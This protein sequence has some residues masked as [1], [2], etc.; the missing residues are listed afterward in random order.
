[1][2][3][4]VGDE[5]GQGELRRVRQTEQAPAGEVQPQDAPQMTGGVLAHREIGAIDRSLGV[6]GPGIGYVIHV[7]SVQRI[8]YSRLPP[9][10][11]AVR[12]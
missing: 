5:L 4:D 11:N 12:R 6:T 1:M 3:H 10:T 7:T 8:D 2:P 9:E